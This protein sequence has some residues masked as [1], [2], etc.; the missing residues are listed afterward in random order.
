MRRPRKEAIVMT[1]DM[2]M[3]A[4]AGLLLV[5][6]VGI[7]I[8]VWLLMLVAAVRRAGARV[9]DA[10]ADARESR[11]RHVQSQVAVATAASVLAEVPDPLLPP[12]VSVA[13]RWTQTTPLDDQPADVIAAMVAGAH[14][15]PL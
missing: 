8:V 5:A 6:L 3:K 2:V 7:P 13:G 14:Q 10:Y 9:H 4:L 12:R 1:A 15:R 11:R